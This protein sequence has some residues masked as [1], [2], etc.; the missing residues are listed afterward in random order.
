MGDVLKIENLNVSFEAYAGDVHA[1]RGVSLSIR[2]GEIVALVGESGC[3]K[4]VTAQSILALN[5]P[6][7]TSITADRLELAGEDILGA[8]EKQMKAIRGKLAGMV[9][10]D[11]MTCLNPTMKVG[12]QITESLFRSK[13]KTR[14]ACQ[15]EAVRLLELVQIPDAAQ[16]AQQYPHQ[17]SGGMRQRVMIAIALARSPRLLIADEPTTA[18]DVTTQFRILLLLREIRKEMGTAVLLIT[19]DL[20][21]VANMADRVVVMYAGKIV[22]EGSV[23]NIFSCAAHPYTQGLLRSLPVE[24]SSGTLF[25]IPGVPPDLYA[26]PKGCAFAQRCSYAMHICVNRQPN[27]FTA[28]EGHA[29]SCWR[30]HPDFEERG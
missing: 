28:G 30:F 23:Q 2:E 12:K 11:P 1:V 20:G 18:L 17:F 24:G 27:E 16:R 15:K 3:G 7:T 10:Q 5:P 21:V 25:S 14:E 4:S 6:Q 26:P 8:T 9:F 29:V 22:E 19:H 13:E